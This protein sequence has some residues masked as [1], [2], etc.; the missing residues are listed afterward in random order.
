MTIMN[1]KREK[2]YPSDFERLV[3]TYIF[4]NFFGCM[5][6]NVIKI[7]KKLYCFVKNLTIFI[8]TPGIVCLDC[9]D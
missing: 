4:G 2:Y 5:I 6:Q 8:K 9:N 1:K 3:K 7:F